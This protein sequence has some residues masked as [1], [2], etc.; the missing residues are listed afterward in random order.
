[1]NQQPDPR[2]YNERLAAAG[3]ETIRHED[4]TVWLRYQGKTIVRPHVNYVEIEV[5]KEFNVQI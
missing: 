4:G 5:K 3:I 1:M 2:S